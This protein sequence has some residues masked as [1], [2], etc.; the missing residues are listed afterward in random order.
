M[1]VT[2]NHIFNSN[3]RNTNIG[4]GLGWRLNLSQKV[5]FQRTLGKSLTMGYGYNRTTFTDYKGRKT[6]YLF[7]H[8]GNTVSVKDH[9]GFAQYSTFFESGTNKNKLSSQSKLQ[10]TIINKLRNHS[11]EQVA[12]W[13]ADSWTGSTANMSQTTEE[14]YSGNQ[15]FKIEKTNA[16][17]R[18]YYRQTLSLEKEKTYTFSGYIKTKHIS[19]YN[20][21]G[22]A[23]FLIYQNGT[24]VPPYISVVQ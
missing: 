6:N 19:N 3:D 23:L 17:Q 11:G 12:Y 18:H 20:E 16:T 7:N 13:I 8:F 2:V 15:S 22:A 14:K 9:Q 4:Y 21:K 24:G 1:P 10:K 5:K